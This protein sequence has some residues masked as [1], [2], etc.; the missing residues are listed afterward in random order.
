V[1]IAAVDTGYSSWEIA[2]NSAIVGIACAVIF[3][4]LM[5][6]LEEHLSGIKTICILV[7]AAVALI[8]SA[9]LVAHVR[10]SRVDNLQDKE[11]RILVSA[12]ANAQ[13]YRAL[14]V[15]STGTDRGVFTI[16]G[17]DCE[18]WT[19]HYRLGLNGRVVT[20]VNFDEP[21][22][23]ANDD[24]GVLSA[25]AGRFDDLEDLEDL[26]GGCVTPSS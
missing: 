11:A 18:D 16:E 8:G 5:A 12:H 17:V 6:C 1:I 3:I 9:F 7:V 22:S 13:G 14:G 10:S 23:E 2:M 21:D 4:S 24:I 15:N 26:I 20:Y 19:L 25:G